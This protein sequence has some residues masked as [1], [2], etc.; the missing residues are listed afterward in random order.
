MKKKYYYGK[1][2]RKMNTGLLNNDINNIYIG[3][4]F[5]F[6]FYPLKFYAFTDFTQKKESEY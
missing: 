4:L 3:F 1:N 5:F 6:I 2:R